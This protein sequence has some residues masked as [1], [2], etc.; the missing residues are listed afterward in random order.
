M[1]NR[2]S[3][4]RRPFT[5]WKDYRFNSILVR[6]FILIIVTLLLAFLGISFLVRIEMNKNLLQEIGKISEQDLEKTKE[7]MDSSVD[8]IRQIAG[9]LSLDPDVMKFL[10]PN[11]TEVFGQ[12]NMIKVKEKIDMYIGISNYIDSI[13]VYSYKNQM[14]VTD[15]KGMDINDFSDTTWLSNLT[16]REYA[17]S[18]IIGRL[19]EN[20][21]P[22]VLSYIQPIRLTQMQFLGGIIIN[23]DIDK[24]NTLVA[25]DSESMEEGFIISDKRGNIIMSSDSKELMKNTSEIERFSKMN[26]NEEGYHIAGKEISTVTG[27]ENFD[28]KYIS[29]VSLEHYDKNM[30]D[31]KGFYVILLIFIVCSSLI[32]AL[33]IALYCYQ[34]VSNLLGLLKDPSLGIDDSNI[35][36]GFKKNEIHEIAL[37]IVRN[38][39]SNEK[40]KEEI[41]QYTQIVDK[42]QVTALQAQISPHFLY[43]T[44]EN[45]RWKAISICQGDNE[46]SQIIMNLSQ[47]LRVS[48]DNERQIITVEEEIQNA[49]LYIK[50][51]ELRY[52]NKL[53]VEWDVDDTVLK[54]PIIKVCLQPLIENAVYHGIKPKRGKGTICIRIIAEETKYRM[55]VIDDGIG[56]SEEE[57][58]K[59]NQMMDEKYILNENHIGVCNV[60]QRI[61]LILNR[62][63]VMHVSSI[64]GEGTTVELE[65]P[66]DMEQKRYEV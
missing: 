1:D 37:N 61:K 49:K 40:M 54:L 22:Y 12:N 42:A 60:N 43:N 24:L 36:L 26:I 5:Y 63:S 39:Y 2:K 4:R 41:S 30:N 19:K 15:S 7:R 51:L 14:I 23:L 6:S 29:T 8:E 64:E 62:E 55:Q 3:K 56:M 65:I 33:I 38:L 44:L 9:Q 58:N 34:P 20:R 32:A 57:L 66:Y 53:K 28:W 18:R 27:S 35:D 11:T 52:E 21:Y 48:L 25:S 47:M 59:L 17:P 46:V 16:E 50:I 10:L 45:I 31:S 13:Y